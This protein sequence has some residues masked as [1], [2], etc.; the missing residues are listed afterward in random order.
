MKRKILTTTAL[1]CS[2]GF[3][4]AAITNG[5]NGNWTSTFRIDG[6]D[7][8]LNFYFKVDGDKVTGTS[9]Q[10]QDEP[11]DINTGKIVGNDFTISFSNRDGE[12][13]PMAGTYYAVGDSI[14]MN[15][16]NEGTNLHIRLKRAGAE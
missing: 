1:V 7:H 6:G 5:I 13:F 3:F 11:K 8:T 4:L 15:I 14:A 10:D 2:F 16:N 12:T 9:Y